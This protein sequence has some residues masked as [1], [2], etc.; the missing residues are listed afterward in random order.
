MSIA[1]GFFSAETTLRSTG[2]GLSRSISTY[3]ELS[4]TQLSTI[5]PFPWGKIR[6]RPVDRVLFG[7]GEVHA[8]ARWF[9]VVA[10]DVYAIWTVAPF[11]AWCSSAGVCQCVWTVRFIPCSMRPETGANDV[12][13]CA[14]TRIT[15]QSGM[16]GKSGTPWSAEAF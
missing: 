13:I 5:L 11:A 8:L 12:N 14:F 1:I 15:M 10:N 4:R 9:S 16:P 2:T 3:S 6:V 7:N